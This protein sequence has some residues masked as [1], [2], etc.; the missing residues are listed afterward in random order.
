MKRILSTVFIV[1]LVALIGL[2]AYIGFHIFEGDN[3]TITPVN[4][5]NPVGKKGRIEAVIE[6]DGAGLRLVEARIRQG[7]KISTIK[8]KHFPIENRLLGS[9]EKT[10]TLHVS[11]FPIDLGLK[12]G[13]AIIEIS[14]FDASLR[15][16]GKGN[17]LTLKIPVKIDFV[18]PVITVLS[19]FH[20]IRPGGVGAISFQV[21]EPVENAGVRV[22]NLFFKAY[23]GSDGIYRALFAIPFNKDNPKKLYIE[24]IDLAKNTGIGGFSY[25][26]LPCKKEVDRINIPDSFLQ[27]KMPG[28]EN[29][30]PEVA[31]PT[32]LE[33]FLKVN[34]ELRKI[35]NDFLLSLSRNSA[36][37]ILWSGAFLRFKGARRSDF[38]DE[39]H[40]FYHG[41][42][43]DQAFHMGVD[44]ASI[45]HAPVRAANNGRV[46]FSGFNGIYGNTVVIDHGLGLMS[47]YSHLGQMTV[48]K[49]QDVKKGDLIGKTDTT[50]LAGGDHLHFGM[51]LSG[52]FVDPKEW[53]D[54][55]WIRE[56][57]IYNL[58]L[59]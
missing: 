54:S 49:G 13:K 5:S 29:M 51:M 18:P 58:S 4:V 57:I 21:N 7:E 41:K 59:R 40:Y 11:V 30:Y 25:R 56:H 52:I 9:T 24:A 31:A 15:N 43:I 16:G 26:I 45:A 36:D 2:S 27:Q 14:A 1:L 55:R 44:I 19:T 12:P 22:D 46:V 42:E 38:G 23:R 3:P 50:G 33:A 47:L 10:Y 20:N 8:S 37:T 28:F 17:E 32:L 39:R 35:N 34:G 53:W 6:D 48:R